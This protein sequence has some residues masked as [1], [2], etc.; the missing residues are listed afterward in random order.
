MTTRPE[1]RGPPG[2][3]L[4]LAA[5]AALALMPAPGRAQARLD[6]VAAVVGAPAP[7]PSADVVLLSDVELRARLSMLARVEDPSELSP[8]PRSLLRATLTEIVGELLIAREA[9]RLQAATPG[10]HD[11]ERERV[12]LLRAAGGQGR[13]SA[14]MV[15]LSA[16]ES[17]L[18]AIARRRALVAGFLSANLE[19]VTEVTDAAL[20]RALADEPGLIE[21]RSREQA[22]DELRARLSRQA[23]DR[24]V[25]RWVAVLRARTEVHLYTEP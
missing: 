13:V 10:H 14:L 15:A 19:G 16:D 22:R 18:V 20:D 8:L 7:G 2:T 4:A 21:G 24:T 12:R 17:E 23:L 9:R 1:R 25:A 3:T 11:V 6:G 5:L